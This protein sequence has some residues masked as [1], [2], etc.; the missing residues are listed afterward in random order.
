MNK[1]LPYYDIIMRCK[2]QSDIKVHP[3]PE[4]YRFKAYEDG[5]E[6][7][8][9]SLENEVNE[10]ETIDDALAYFNRTFMPYKEYLHDRMF[11]ILDD[12]GNYVATTS[13][14]FKDDDQRHYALIHW[15]SVSPTQQGKG[16]GSCIVSYALSQFVKVEP[17]ENEIFLHT[18]T[19]SYKAIALYYKYGFKITMTP[20]VNCY[21]DMKCMEVLKE[22]LPSELLDK[23]VE[24]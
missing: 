17:Y 10:F 14:W 4:G 23:L 1:N 18:Q 15:V 6:K 13:A 7:H 3:L 21:T 16:L 2:K 19:W 20:L 9:A 24:Q 11:F 12:K 22:V 5:D 8:W